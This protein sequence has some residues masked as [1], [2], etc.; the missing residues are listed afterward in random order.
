MLSNL[1]KESMHHAFVLEGSTSQSRAA[2]LDFIQKEFL[3]APGHNDLFILNRGDFG[4]DDVQE[5]VSINSRKPVSGNEKVIVLTVHSIS[6]QAQN[7]M[8]KTLEEPRPGTYI[9]ILTNTASIFLPTILSRVQV[10]RSVGGDVGPDNSEL[11]TKNS[12][13][14]STKDSKITQKKHDALSKALSAE[15]FLKNS[16]ADRLAQVKDILDLKSDEEIGDSDI[17]AFVQEVEKLAHG[18]AYKATK[19]STGGTKMADKKALADIAQIFM[20][21]SEYMRDTSSSK[22][23]LLEYMALRLPNMLI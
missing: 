6:H 23:L 19:E 14:L 2:L 16:K 10:V 15:T 9:F 4:V 8:L 3:M 12:A 1:N 21:V 18:L 13:P 20:K 22:K 7:A 11:A 17:F 5:I